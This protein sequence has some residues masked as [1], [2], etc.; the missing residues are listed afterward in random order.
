[1]IRKVLLGVLASIALIG[2]AL[3]TVY[4]FQSGSM[5]DA[6]LTGS[7][8]IDTEA[9]P[10]E[11]SLRGDDGPVLLYLH[12]TP[13]GYDQVI[14]ED[15]DYRILTPSR[16]GYLRT[17][18]E[19]GRTPEQQAQAYDSLLDA[20][21]IESVIVMGASGGGPS[22]IEFA[23]IFPQRTIAL[24]TLEVVTM[25][26]PEEDAFLP[27]SFVS[28]LLV[29]VLNVMP[30]E[31]LLETLLPD[32][33][34]QQIALESPEAIAGM[35]SLFW[36]LWPTDWRSEGLVNDVSEFSRLSLPVRNVRAPTLI[37]HGT[38]DEDVPYSHAEF[39]AESIPGAHLHTVEGAD[40]MMPFTHSREV[41][42]A[43]EEFLSGIEEPILH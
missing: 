14:I 22:A 9:G 16:P 41:L 26:S 23:A 36:S 24:I 38:A 7:K 35:K 15:Q 11:Y 12:G 33:A 17:P 25:P 43:I 5:R 19:V 30:D 32:P 27:P 39:L 37:I 4:S 6:L 28:W 20:L 31:I 18:L 10:I 8:V 1:M 34:N 29:S 2:V 42:Q 13:G 3:V 40:H 21:N